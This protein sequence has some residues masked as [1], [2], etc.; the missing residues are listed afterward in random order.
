MDA[1]MGQGDLYGEKAW[2]GH[3]TIQEFCQA[4]VV[5]SLSDSWTDMSVTLLLQHFMEKQLVGTG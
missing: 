3:S 5:L 1:C 4:D 2:E